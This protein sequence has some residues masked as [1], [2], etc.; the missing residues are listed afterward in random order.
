MSQSLNEERTFI[1]Q[2]MELEGKAIM[3]NIGH[4]NSK[5]MDDNHH[6]SGT[7]VL[8]DEKLHT[9]SSTAFS[10]LSRSTD[11]ADSNGTLMT[12]SAATDNATSNPDSSSTST[13][14]PYQSEAMRCRRLEMN[15]ASAKARRSN[16]KWLVENLTNEVSELREKLKQSQRHNVELMKSNAQIKHALLLQQQ[17]RHQQQNTHVARAQAQVLVQQQKLTPN[18]CLQQI[19]RLK[20]K[21][22]RE[23]QQHGQ[24]E[25]L[26]Q[27][28]LG[29]SNNNNTNTNVALLDGLLQRQQQQQPSQ[30]LQQQLQQQHQQQRTDQLRMPNF[31][32]GNTTT[33]GLPITTALKTTE[34]LLADNNKSTIT[35]TNANQPLDIRMLP[36]QP[37]TLPPSLYTQQQ[38]PNLKMEAQQLSVSSLGTP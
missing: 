28:L 29:G 25:L 33:T 21:M 22:H 35:N 38:Q 20:L 36:P 8:N 26:K 32:V 24:R 6:P 30:Q 27:Q 10:S 19:Q 14:Q 11:V 13:S 31:V 2:Q 15:R 4:S 17:S 5:K 3:E 9:T 7:S 16:Q 18:A 34:Q 12:Y 23:Q 1:A 37:V